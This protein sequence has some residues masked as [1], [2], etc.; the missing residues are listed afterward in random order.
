M[1]K[2]D[3]DF[4]EDDPGNNENEES[5]S[6]VP[7]ASKSAFVRPDKKRKMS[8]DDK[9][10]N[11]SDSVKHN[12]A[13]SIHNYFEDEDYKFCMLVMCELKAVE[14]LQVKQDL[15]WKMHQLLREAR[16]VNYPSFQLMP[17]PCRVN[18]DTPSPFQPNS[19]TP[20]PYLQSVGTPGNHN[21]NL[22][23][24][25]PVRPYPG[26]G[27]TPSPYNLPGHQEANS[28]CS[29]FQTVPN[30]Q[31]SYQPMTNTPM[32]YSLGPG[33]IN[34][35]QPSSNLQNPCMTTLNIHIPYQPADTSY[36]HHQTSF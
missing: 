23:V 32:C 17:G 12:E 6:V 10:Q 3:E 33:M 21:E 7:S 1:H 5:S 4:S 19:R 26:M 24:P 8:Q 9:A 14:N 20:S 2:N 30:I 11:V 27:L 16:S 29:A 25:V 31:G 22:R 13:A 36:S 18:L 15:K 28:S 34:P 35:A